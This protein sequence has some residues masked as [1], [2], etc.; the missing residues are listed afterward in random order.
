MGIA[1]TVSQDRIAVYNAREHNLQGVHLQVPRNALVVFC[2]VSGSGK[3]SMAFDTIYAEGQRRYVESLSTHARQ[4]LGVMSRPH[5]D[6]IDGLSPAIAIDQKSASPN[7]RSTVATITEI[8]DYLRVLYARLG[9]PFCYQCGEEIRAFT[10]QQIVD[11]IMALGEGTRCLILAPLK[12]VEKQREALR[13]ARR[14]GY[15]RA[16]VD[17]KVLDLAEGID[18]QGDGHR[19]E[20]VVDR[21]VVSADVRSRLAEAIETA[22][23]QGDDTVIAQPVGGEDLEFSTRF[24]CR[25][26][27][28][29]YPE[30]TPSSFSFNSPHGMCPDCGGLGVVTDIDPQLFVADPT[31]SILDG[32]L[33]IYGRIRT[34]HVEHIMRGL[35]KHYG[36]D[37]DTPWQDLPERAREVVLYGSGDEKIR[38]GYQTRSGRDYE[39]EKAFE[40]L[41]PASERGRTNTR[42]KAKQEYFD[43]YYASMPCPACGGSRLRRESRSVRIGGL[44]LPE[45]SALDVSAC[46][47]FFGN[48]DLGATGGLV[49]SELL[50]EV[51]ARLTFMAEV[52]VG[53][54]TLDRAAPTLS[55]GEAQRIRLATQIGSGLAGVLYILDEPSIGLHARDQNRLLKTLLELRD[56][57]NT[58]IVVEHDPATIEAADYVVEFGPG[59]GVRGGKVTFAGEV[60]EMKASQTSLTGGYL[61]GR[62]GVK[63]PVHR[64]RGTGHS[65]QVKHATAHNLKSV[66]VD[67]PLGRLVVVTGVS[68][69]GKS[70]LVHDVL[71][72]GLRRRLHGSMDKPGPHE[73]LAGVEHVDKIVNI[74]QSPIGRTPRSNPATYSGLFAPIRELFAATPDARTRGYKPGRFS[75]NVKGGRCE[76]C[77]GDGVVK[78][79]MQFL[80]DVYVPCEEC[81]GTRYNRETLQ[82]LYKGKS[83]ADVLSLTAAEALEHFHNVPS[84]ER[85]LR[86]INDVGLDY[87]TLGQPATTL[88]GGEA[89]R[90]KLA[91]ELSKAETG[92]T[93]YILDEPTT[94]LHFADIEKLMEVLNRLVDAG[95][96]V[97][98]IEHNLDVIRLADW[99]ID[100]GPEGGREGGE[101]VAAGTPEQ[102]ID[103][104]RSHTARF[105]KA[106]LENHSR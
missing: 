11:R 55:G 25:R 101:V 96:T 67:F 63:N 14:A 65:L 76:A 39:Y 31:K 36:F 23:G 46:L 95:N 33:E 58:V 49:A 71:Y 62:L 7:P 69:S 15:V 42:S 22:L 81:G 1:G 86:T 35:A 84:V 74:D 10:P 38:F 66:T 83:I 53:Y 3:S 73:S 57:G 5:V 87:I 92:K 24:A 82:I 9:R 75:F 21:I 102:I 61:T 2:G 94:G 105:L 41:V 100:M 78:I 28:I 97:L 17:G 54:L 27:D 30:L 47:D 16:R 34:G 37:L 93:L 32:A 64:R 13:T 26:C 79:E 91:R 85:I 48:L 43:R 6:H 20:L 103:S 90:L 106:A 19:I 80:S 99:V 72:L 59:A 44:T 18:L 77:E 68:G 50:A 51:R 52:G 60:G 40:G 88:S 45:V 4:V 104:D 8:H 29:T 89:Q 56:L 12:V 70:T 98:V